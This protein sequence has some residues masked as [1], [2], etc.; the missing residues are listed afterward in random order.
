MLLMF[1]NLFAVISKSGDLG[2]SRANISM[3]DYQQLRG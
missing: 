3:H 1:R 2:N